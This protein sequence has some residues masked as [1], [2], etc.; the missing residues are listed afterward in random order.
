MRQLRHLERIA[1]KSK[2]FGSGG[3]V[4]KTNQSLVNKKSR[5]EVVYKAKIKGLSLSC[6]LMEA[7]VGKSGY[8][9]WLKHRHD[10]AERDRFAYGIIEK[11]FSDGKRK[12]G[13]R[14]IAMI[15]RR[16]YGVVLNPKRICRIKKE[17]N[18]ITQTR[19]CE[20]LN[21]KHQTAKGCKRNIR[22]LKTM[23]KQMKYEATQ[24]FERLA[25]TI[26]DWFTPIIRMWRFTKNNGITE[27]FHRKMKLIQRMAYGYRNFQNYRLRVLVLCGVFH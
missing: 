19:I 13:I 27:G 2:V 20:L 10:R 24:E 21:R 17:H 18:L 1:G 5:Y 14:Q 7:N 4:P 16:K 23:M 3:R 9:Y 25:E 15:A 8:Y 26:S 22:E 12:V 6:L 11:I